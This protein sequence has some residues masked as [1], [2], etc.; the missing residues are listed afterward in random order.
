MQHECS[1]CPRRELTQGALELLHPL[2]GIRLIGRIAVWR[3][4]DFPEDIENVNRLGLPRPAQPMLIEHVIRQRKYIGLWHTDRFVIRDPD[5]SEE[6]LLQEVGRI[7]SIAHTRK[8][9]PPQAL[10]V[11]GGYRINEGLAFF[12]GHALSRSTPTHTWL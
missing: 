11:L 2:G 12:R 5:Q 8:Q 9:E 6:D 7:R 10:A 3:T 1:A 4:L